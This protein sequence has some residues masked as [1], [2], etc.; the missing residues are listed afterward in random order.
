MPSLDLSYPATT[1]TPTIPR[2][3]D[4]RKYSKRL[5][6]LSEFYWV[7]ADQRQ[8]LRA[9]GAWIELIHF[10]PVEHHI[11]DRAIAR[12]C[13]GRPDPSSSATIRRS[14]TESFKSGVPKYLK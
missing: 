14:A 10:K 13:D 2:F 7:R 5:H 3:C 11:E 12:L 4:A 1:I 9:H 8:L 6:F